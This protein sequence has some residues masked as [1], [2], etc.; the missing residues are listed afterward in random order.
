MLIALSGVPWGLKG[1][2]S[3]EG[4]GGGGLEGLGGGDDV[5]AGDAGV[6]AG[7]EVL[8][9]GRW[10]LELSLPPLLLF[11][12]AQWAGPLTGLVNKGVVMLLGT[13][14]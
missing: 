13:I 5:V 9:E 11:G 12:G 1:K 4:D 8:R 7:L 2:K 3:E 14:R 6:D 10:G